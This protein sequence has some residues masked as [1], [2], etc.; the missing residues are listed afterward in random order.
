MMRSR[1]PP[2]DG[3]VSTVDGLVEEAVA[4]G[5]K[6]VLCNRIYQRYPNSLIIHSHNRFDVTSVPLTNDVSDESGLGR[7]NEARRVGNH[8]D[9]RCST[10]GRH[11]T[12]TGWLLR[13]RPDAYDRSAGGEPVHRRHVGG[14]FPGEDGLAVVHGAEHVGLALNSF[15]VS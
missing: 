10:S 8:Q 7:D 12:W 4:W 13:G 9:R 2:R 1:L 6:R 3:A 5:V 14:W 11:S 15:L